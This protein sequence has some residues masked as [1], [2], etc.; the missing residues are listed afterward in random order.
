MRETKGKIVVRKAWLA[1]WCLALLCACQPPAEATVTG[2]QTATQTG[3]T[4]TA[5]ATGQANREPAAQTPQYRLNPAPQQGYEVTLEVT[6]AP[7]EFGKMRWSAHYQASGCS[8]VTSAWA[9]ARAEPTQRLE[10]PFKRTEAGRYVAT[11]YLDAL[12][13]ENYFGNGV[14]EWRLL[15]IAAG[16]SATSAV[17]DTQFVADMPLKQV[18]A[19]LPVKR[20]YLKASY[21]RGDMPGVAAHG[22]DDAMKIPESFRGQVFSMTLT[23][24]VLP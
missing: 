6:G 5:G 4:G 10:V 9:G 23:P 21:P 7:G 18:Q 12:A 15:S 14:C 2:P 11:V 1:P 13:N 20:Y 24:K 3:T 22:V 16:L 8:Y 17:E 19:G